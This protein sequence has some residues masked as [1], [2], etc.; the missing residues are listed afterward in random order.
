MEIKR[1][2]RFSKHPKVSLTNARKEQKKKSIVEKN[3]NNDNDINR[4][5][6]V[7]MNDQNI[8]KQQHF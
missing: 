5:N 4:I 2:K 7:D 8:I 6:M 1:N 3:R